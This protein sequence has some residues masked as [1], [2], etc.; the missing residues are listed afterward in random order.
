MYASLRSVQ[1]NIV[2]VIFP[3]SFIQC[4]RDFYCDALLVYQ[5]AEIPTLPIWSVVSRFWNSGN[6]EKIAYLKYFFAIWVWDVTYYTFLS[7]NVS[8][9]L[10]N[11][12]RCG[13][14]MQ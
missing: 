8:P 10:S 7:Y 6:K 4:Y 3:K 11:E 9:S 13:V 1:H 2:V 14:K 12:Y 5:H